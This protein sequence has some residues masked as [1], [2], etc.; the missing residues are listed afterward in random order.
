MS[1]GEN[2]WKGGGTSVR[3][4]LI[5]TLPRPFSLLCVVVCVVLLPCNCKVGKLLKVM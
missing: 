2:I 1:N 3:K 5:I 4:L